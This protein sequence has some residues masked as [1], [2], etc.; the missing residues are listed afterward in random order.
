MA[1]CS[2]HWLHR[3]KWEHMDPPACLSLA[4][5]VSLPQWRMSNGRVPPAP[6]CLPSPAML[7]SSKARHSV[8][9]RPSYGN[10]TGWQLQQ[11]HLPPS[12]H[13][14]QL[15]HCKTKLFITKLNTNHLNQ[16]WVYSQR[17]LL[18]LPPKVCS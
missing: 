12:F 10:M 8:R 15:T 2:Q 14:G 9:V 6:A 1:P 18:P 5:A 13:G 7:P 4:G 16:G 3:F 17:I 11:W